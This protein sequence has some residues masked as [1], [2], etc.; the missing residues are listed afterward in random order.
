MRE[1]H[2]LA[3]VTLL[4]WLGLDRRKVGSCWFTERIGPAL[5]W[6]NTAKKQVY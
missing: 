4:V 2:V 6:L 1:K 3:D 5:F